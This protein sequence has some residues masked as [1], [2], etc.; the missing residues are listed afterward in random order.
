MACYLIDNMQPV[1]RYIIAAT[2]LSY[3]DT[4]VLKEIN[5]ATDNLHI[6]DQESSDFEIISGGNFHAQYQAQAMDLL[7]M[8]S[9][10]PGSNDH[11]QYTRHYRNENIVGDTKF[12]HRQRLVAWLC[13][14]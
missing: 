3:I 13:A 9:T 10:D 5:S 12:K 1:A 14:G 2:R 6:F 8:T 7:A 4:I 11:R